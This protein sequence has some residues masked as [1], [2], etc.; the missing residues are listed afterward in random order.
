MSPNVHNLLDTPLR[1]L[2]PNR[3]TVVGVIDVGSD[4]ICCLIAKLKPRQRDG[5][6]S[7]GTH[8][9]QV[10]GVGFHRSSGIKSGVVMDMEAAER[11]IRRSIDSAERMAGVTLESVMVN[12]S[13]GRIAS[14]TF[15]AEVRGAEIAETEVQRVLQAGRDYSVEEGRIVLHSLPIGYAL[16]GQRGIGDP[17]GMVG[18]RLGIDMNI[19]TGDEGPVQNLLL[20][21]ERCHLDVEAVVATP[22]AAGLGSLTP[23]EMRIGSACIDVGAGT[24]A[25]SVF[26]NDAFLF[27]D[28]VAVGGHHVTMDLARGLSTSLADAE[29]IKTLYGSAIPSDSDEREMISVPA[30]GSDEDGDA[31]QV[32]RSLLT[33]IIH[34]RIEEILEIVRDRLKQSGAYGLTGRR[35]VITGG[36]SAQTGLLP[37]AERILECRARQGRP[38]AVQGLP[39]TAHAPAFS[40]AMGLLIYPQVAQVEHFEATRQAGL[41]TGTGGYI[42]KFGRWL[43]RSV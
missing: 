41:L 2:P 10:L 5:A 32:P 1:P 18:Q 13:C 38:V 23:D 35:V 19:V 17:A 6:R 37:L 15:S 8:D 14:E 40:V 33:G 12:I 21:I 4:K 43:K 34:P 11:A 39:E 27:A 36:A 42:S 3:S 22:Y 26:F 28:A 31:T 7:I 25:V 29:R 30:V 24:T 16:D 20:C 9:I